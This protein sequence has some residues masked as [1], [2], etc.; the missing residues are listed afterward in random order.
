[1]AIYTSDLVKAV[2]KAAGDIGTNSF[3][4]YAFMVELHM[5]IDVYF[6]ILFRAT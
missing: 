3:L 6:M 4:K 5:L 1:M 2:R